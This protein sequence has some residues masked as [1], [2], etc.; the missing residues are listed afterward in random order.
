MGVPISV[1]STG[2]GGTEVF[3]NI[4]RR[5]RPNLACEFHFTQV[6]SDTFSEKVSLIGS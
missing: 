5:W 1:E 3:P 4:C 6:L 2:L